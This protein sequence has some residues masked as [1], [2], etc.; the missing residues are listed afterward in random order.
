MA[1]MSCSSDEHYWPDDYAAGDTCNCGAFYLIET[2]PHAHLQVSD[3][4]AT[5]LSAGTEI[6]ALRAAVIQARREYGAFGSL[7]GE[8]LAQMDAACWRAALAG[9]ME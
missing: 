3:R 9:G 5:A 4:V 1:D 7:S 8:T 2:V 6:V